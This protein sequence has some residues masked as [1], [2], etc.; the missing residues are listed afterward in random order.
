MRT[1][2]EIKM[3]VEKEIETNIATVEKSTDLYH[4]V[5]DIIENVARQE[6]MIHK[7]AVNI[8]AELKLYSWGHLDH[9]PT[10]V[11]NVAFKGLQETLENDF[12]R[13]YTKANIEY[14]NNT[15]VFGDGV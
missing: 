2:T 10:D 1:L 15:K 7:T 6:T 14:V 12:R 11:T 9:I 5:I 4:Y 8:M 13:F 3:A